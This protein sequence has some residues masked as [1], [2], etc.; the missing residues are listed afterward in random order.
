MRVDDALTFESVTACS[1]TDQHKP[2]QSTKHCIQASVAARV[3]HTITGYRY[4]KMR[5]SPKCTVAFHP[6]VHPKEG[7]RR[8][9]QKSSIRA[10]PRRVSLQHQLGYRQQRPT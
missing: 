6:V 8:I 9:Y 10:L 2:N 1:V 3:N 5:Q 7:R 4:K